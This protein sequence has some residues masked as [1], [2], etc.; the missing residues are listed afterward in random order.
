MYIII[1]PIIKPK[2]ARK[3]FELP[4]QRKF[5]WESGAP[6]EILGVSGLGVYDSFPHRRSTNHVSGISLT[7]QRPRSD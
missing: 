3:I 4:A 2:A 5:F 1:E 7:L 6:S